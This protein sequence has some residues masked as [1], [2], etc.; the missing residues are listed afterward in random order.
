ML[1]L[2]DHATE[3]PEFSLKPAVA[4]TAAQPTSLSGHAYR[5]LLRA[6]RDSSRDAS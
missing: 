1:G 4:L 5:A 3:P 6:R 2:G